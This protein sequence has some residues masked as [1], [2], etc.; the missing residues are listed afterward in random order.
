MTMIFVRR[1]SSYWLCIP[2]AEEKV[3]KKVDKKAA[4]LVGE[5]AETKELLSVNL[6]VV[7]SKHR[8]A[9]TY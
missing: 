5:T 9:P 1:S 7:S 4:S 3:D 8:G 6:L 2:V